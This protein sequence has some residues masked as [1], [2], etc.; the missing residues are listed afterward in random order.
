MSE[1]S[2]GEVRPF[3]EEV[4]AYSNY[5][6]GTHVAGI[7]IEG[8]PNAKVITARI[9]FSHKMV[10]EVPTIAK[11]YRHAAAVTE[12]IEYLKQAG[13]RV[14]NMS[15]GGS[16]SGIESALELNNI[17]ETPEERK[18]LAR[19]IFNI[20]KKALEDAMASAPE[21]LFVCSAGNSDV[22]NEFEEFLPASIELPNLMTVGAVDQ[23]GEETSFTSFGKVDIYAN[24]FEVESYVPGGDRLKFSGTSMSSPNVVNLAAKLLAIDS[25][26]TIAQLR[27]LIVDGGDEQSAGERTVLL[28][29]P[30]QSMELLR[31][32]M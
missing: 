12:T 20:S 2:Q 30:K 5:S 7:A 27:D 6:H 1:L 14:V 23:A 28:I 22:D 15:W 11:A 3:I 13:V 24:G 21:V 26:L 31:Q 10:P 32:K 19:R 29:N 16:I 9:T 25:S 18:Q 8:N 17:G 4:N